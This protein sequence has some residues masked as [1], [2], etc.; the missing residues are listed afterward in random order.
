MVKKGKGKSSA[1]VPATASATA[2]VTTSTAAAASGQERVIELKEAGNREV[3]VGNHAAAAKLYTTAISLMGERLRGEKVGEWPLEDRAALARLHSNRALCYT[4]LGKHEDAI[5]EGKN[6]TKLYPSWA[7]GWY[8]FGVA[9][10]EAKG[11]DGR[12]YFCFVNAQMKSPKDAS[13]AAALRGS[14]GTLS[15]IYT[16][17]PRDG[18]EPEYVQHTPLFLIRVA[19]SP[20]L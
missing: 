10:T 16:P 14:I 15:A 3:G 19:T 11:H 6:I 20:L 2:P 13:I 7:K 18:G 4:T 5:N 8:R 1:K 17:V 9:L 12:A